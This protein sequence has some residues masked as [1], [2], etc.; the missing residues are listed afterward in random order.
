M[1]LHTASINKGKTECSFQVVVNKPSREF[2]YYKE[3]ECDIS[4]I[5]NPIN[6]G[7]TK[8]A[9]QIIKASPKNDIVLLN[10]DCLCDEKWLEYLHE[11]AYGHYHDKVGMAVPR[12]KNMPEI[13]RCGVQGAGCRKEDPNWR[14]IFSSW[15]GFVCVYLKREMIE[16]IGLLDE[17]YPHIKSDKKYCELAMRSKY[18]F[19]HTHKSN[20]YHLLHGS[21]PIKSKGRTWNDYKHI[22]KIEKLLSLCQHIIDQ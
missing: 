13:R 3:M 11:S 12:F 6:F 2:S 18:N 9:N 21:Q 7:F 10:S 16:N 22:P 5:A 1:A 17:R 15:F 4:V 19:A 14:S 8:S 20:I